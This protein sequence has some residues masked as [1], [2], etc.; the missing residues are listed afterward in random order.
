MDFTLGGAKGLVAT[1]LAGITVSLDTLESYAELYKLLDQS[2]SAIEGEGRWKTDLEFG[3]QMMNAVNP[4]VIKKCTAI[5][6]NFAVTDDLVKPFLTRGK[7]LTQ[8]IEVHVII[9]AVSNI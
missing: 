9:V 7:T 8:E 2:P 4:V 6:S 1:Q 5:P 3:R